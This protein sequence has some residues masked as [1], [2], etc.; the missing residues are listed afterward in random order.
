MV[1]LRY[2]MSGPANII[3]DELSD[4]LN[5]VSVHPVVY[6][7]DSAGE[8][9]YIFYEKINVLFIPFRFNY[10][11]RLDA[12][13]KSKTIT[14]SSVVRKGVLLKLEFVLVPHGSTTEITEKVSIQANVFI[15][16]IFENVLTR[17]HKKLFLNIE[18]K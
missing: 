2:N 5:F 11:V 16:L 4:M 9:E 10:K 3:Y 8:N 7:I 6:K 15:R 14:M 13:E 18:N 1:T 17:V 12:L